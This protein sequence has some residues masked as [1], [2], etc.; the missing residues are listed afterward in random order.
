MVFRLL[1]SAWNNPWLLIFLCLGFWASN[2]VAARLAVGN[3]SPMALG[4]MR[5]IVPT[6]IMTPIV[7]SQMKKHK[8]LI[9]QHWLY[10]TLI[11]LSGFSI[12]SLL[13]YS[14]GNFTSGV[15]IAMLVATVPVFTILIAWIFAR[16]PVGPVVIA[17]V[18]LTVSGAA[19][20][21]SRGDLQVLRNMSFNAGDLMIIA[22]SIL[23][24]SFT[25]GLRKRPPF[26]P[27]LFF[28]LLAVIAMVTSLPALAMEMATGHFIWPTWLGLAILIYV[29]TFPTILSQ[30]FYMRVIELIGPQRTSLFYNMVPVM[31]AMMSVAFLGEAFHAYHFI[32]FTLVLSGIALAEIWRARQQ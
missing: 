17:G 22:A 1:K 30:T 9:R 20:V 28:T 13:F 23:H 7:W 18:I 24:A 29:G 15:N 12:Y 14:A 16:D 25:V 27:M 32:A 4:S 19:V 26:P 2:V 3:V 11:S 31:G 10:L 8:Q 6:L 21:A 5:W